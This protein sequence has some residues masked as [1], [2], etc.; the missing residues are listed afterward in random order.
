MHLICFLCQTLK[1]KGKTAD[2]KK[3]AQVTI[4]IFLAFPRRLQFICILHVVETESAGA[5]CSSLQLPA[6]PQLNYAKSSD[7]MYFSPM[8]KQVGNVK[9]VHAV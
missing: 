4:S 2:P 8:I 5:P 3:L 6:A 7:Y 1:A 9:L